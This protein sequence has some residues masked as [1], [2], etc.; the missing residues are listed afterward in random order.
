MPQSTYS[1]ISKYLI[2]L[3]FEKVVIQGRGINADVRFILRGENTR[4][5]TSTYLKTFGT[6]EE[7][8]KVENL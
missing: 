8:K 6:L 7:F 4:A 5:F 3:K 2:K 1:K